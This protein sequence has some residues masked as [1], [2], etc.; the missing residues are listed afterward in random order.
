MTLLKPGP[1]LGQT[2]QCDGIICSI[3]I[4]YP[5]SLS[6]SIYMYI[7]ALRVPDEGYSRNESCVFITCLNILRNYIPHFRQH[8]NTEE[9]EN[10]LN[11]SPMYDGGEP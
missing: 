6:L 10:K 3:C 11:R 5:V 7:L 4:Q 1:G 9:E 8:D 2:Q